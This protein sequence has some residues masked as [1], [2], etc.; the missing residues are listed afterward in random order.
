MIWRER[1][2]YK[3]RR[4]STFRNQSEYLPLIIG[5]SHQ[6]A[7]GLPH[8]GAIMNAKGGDEMKVISIVHFNNLFRNDSL[9]S[10]WHHK[11][12]NNHI[13]ETLHRALTDIRKDDPLSKMFYFR[14]QKCTKE[15]KKG[16]VL[17]YVAWLFQW[18]LFDDILV[19]FLPI[20]HTPEDIDQTFSV[21]LEWRKC[22]DT[23]TLTSFVESWKRFT[24]SIRPLSECMKLSIC[25]I[26]A[27]RISWLTFNSLPTFY[28]LNYNASRK[29]RSHCPLPKP[30]ARKTR[31]PVWIRY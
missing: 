13:V 14:F 29:L 2:K 5:S 17:K 18:K 25:Q 20:G 3:M 10:Q 27:R 28:T 30:T 9:F 6:S 19:S 1:L 22:N 16:Y 4:S 15:N 31:C 26:F 21:T 7:Y 8:L 24:A 23:I 12:D 11:I